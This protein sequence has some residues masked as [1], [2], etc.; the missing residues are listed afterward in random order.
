MMDK[1]ITNY[2]LLGAF[3][4]KIIVYSTI[5]FFFSKDSLR[6]DGGKHECHFSAT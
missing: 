2:K 1:G 6:R 4:A 3:E 5:D